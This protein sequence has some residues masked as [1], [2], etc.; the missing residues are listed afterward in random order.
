MGGSEVGGDPSHEVGAHG[1]GVQRGYRLKWE[2]LFVQVAHFGVVA[3]EI[4][5]WHARTLAKQKVFK[6]RARGEEIFTESKDFIAGAA[7]EAIEYFAEFYE[8][9]CWTVIIV[10]GG[11]W[12]LP[13]FIHK[14]PNQMLARA[15]LLCGPGVARVTPHP[16]KSGGAT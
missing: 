2:R 9:R 4:Y 8:L 11:P 1:R 15:L 7:V 16:A 3:T 13:E 12:Q 14:I 5:A 10:V 6:V